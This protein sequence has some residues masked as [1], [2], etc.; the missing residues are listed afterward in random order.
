V[1][2]TTLRLAHPLI[3]FITEELWQTVAP[4]AGRSVTEGGSIA[5]ADYPVAQ[6]EKI[7]ETAE[8]WV[9]G[10]KALVD[11]VRALRGETGLSPATRTPLVVAGDRD[12]V[13]DYAP[14]LKALAR[15]SEVD[16]VGETLP[17]SPAPVQV[18]G[19]FRLMLR[20]EVDVAAERARLGKEIGRL[21]GEIGRA[22]AKLGNAGFV[23]RA[24]AAVVQQER[25]RLT[26]FGMTLERLRAQLERLD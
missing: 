11:A 7:D 22:E 26:G 9:A 20:V 21:E 25:E 8:R 24:P 14:Y 12:V 23:A 3:P 4:L 19:E 13:L 17:V 1:L 15:L 6:P 18:I 10:L 16:A 2:E 5:T